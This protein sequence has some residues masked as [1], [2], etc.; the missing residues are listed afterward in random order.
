MKNTKTQIWY[1]HP[2]NHSRKNDK[3]VAIE[4]TVDED[5]NDEM[6]GASVRASKDGHTILD[7]SRLKD[8][9]TP[10]HKQPHK[11]LYGASAETT[12]GRKGVEVTN[13]TKNGRKIYHKSV[14]KELLPGALGRAY[15]QQ[16]E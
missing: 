12:K 9:S 15:R 8:G 10:K 7:V 5:A 1:V 16:N 3:S 4:F 2:Y 13:W 6:N 14:T 11:M